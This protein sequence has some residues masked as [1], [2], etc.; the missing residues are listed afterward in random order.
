[1]TYVEHPFAPVFNENS[2]VLILGTIPSPQSRNHHFYY[3]HPQNAFWKVLS[4]LL[5]EPLPQTP[6]EKSTFLLVH[7]IALWDVLH[8]CEIKG[9]SDSHIRN[10]VPNDFSDLFRQAPIQK[11]FTTGKKATEL[12]QKLCEPHTGV[13]TI[14]LPSTSPANRYWYPFEKLLLTYQIILPWL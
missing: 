2:S 5:K 10:P 9:A 3:S 12:Y 14:Y 11:V 4:T 13:P 6:E 1:M 7:H 8:A